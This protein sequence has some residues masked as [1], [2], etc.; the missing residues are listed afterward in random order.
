MYTYKVTNQNHIAKLLADGLKPEDVQELVL[1]VNNPDLFIDNMLDELAGES[2]WPLAVPPGLITDQED[3]LQ[4]RGRARRIIEMMTEDI[5]L[6]GLK[7]L[8]CGCGAGHT[9][10]EAV[11][12]GAGTV[13]GYDIK[14][15][16]TWNTLATTNLTFT[17]SWDDV[18]SKGPYDIIFL[19]DVLDHVMD[20][21]PEFLLADCADAL[22]KDGQIIVRLHPWIS[23]HGTHL[24]TGLNRAYAHV[25]FPEDKLK[26]R[27]YE[28]IPTRKVIHPMVT[29]KSWVSQAG[30][31]IVKE[32]KFQE[33][34]E[35]YF[36]KNDLLR[37]LVQ[38][39][40]NDSPMQDYKEGRGDL[41]R[42]M[43]FQFV[44]FILKK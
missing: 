40:Y 6:F 25:I 7:F 35:D 12:K 29:Y 5:D 38:K 8:D 16:P 36:L 44:D 26:E 21:D 24:Y 9:A 42:V 18:L 23:R 34:A 14:R 4:L 22:S 2:Y 15:F 39:H 13:V 30:L 33:P 19:Y 41:A 17:S 43:S 27:G 1:N 11:V 37:A 3:E 10:A 20:R 31:K 28:G 32:D